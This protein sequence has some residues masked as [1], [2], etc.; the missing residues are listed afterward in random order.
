MEK[1]VAPIRLSLIVARREEL[2]LAWNTDQFVPVMRLLPFSRLYLPES[3]AGEVHC[4]DRIYKLERGRMLLIPAFANIKLS[5]NE[6]LVRY[7][8]L[9][10]T[11]SAFLQHKG[12]SKNVF[13]G[14]RFFSICCLK[15]ISTRQAPKIPVISIK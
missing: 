6:R 10:P 7:N 13:L 12:T 3:G 4:Q 14:G 2:G 1:F 9:N 15:K 5:C 8:E 11:Q